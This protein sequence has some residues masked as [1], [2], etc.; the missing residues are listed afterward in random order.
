M[1]LQERLSKEQFEKVDALIV[2]SKKKYPNC[3]AGY[4]VQIVSDETGIEIDY[5]EVLERLEFHKKK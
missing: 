1:N 2:E 3:T 4:I 5:K